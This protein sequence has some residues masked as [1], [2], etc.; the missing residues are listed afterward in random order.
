[1][2]IDRTF[3]RPAS[4]LGPVVFLAGTVGVGGVVEDLGVGLAFDEGVVDLE[5]A[6]LE[7]AG[8]VGEAVSTLEGL[9]EEELAFFEVSGVVDAEAGGVVLGLF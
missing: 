3:S 2:L 6:G 1:M 5:K 8:A 9:V 4:L 7:A